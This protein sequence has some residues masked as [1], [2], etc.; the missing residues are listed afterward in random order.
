MTTTTRLTTAT[1]D[2]D[3]IAKANATI[4]E[5]FRCSEFYQTSRYR[6]LADFDG[7]KIGIVIATRTWRFDNH[8]LNKAD[9]DRLLEAKSSGKIDVGFVVAAC[10]SKEYVHIYVA[11]RE[12][13][14]LH[15]VLKDVP[16]RQSDF[17]PFWILRPD[18]SPFGLATG[19]D[20][21]DF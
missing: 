14:E 19:R 4:P 1:A 7:T 16:P 20:A 2:G 15:H 9:F 6:W 10:I 21:N 13:E 11:H 18:L 5:I 17:G 12:A 3:H 8:D